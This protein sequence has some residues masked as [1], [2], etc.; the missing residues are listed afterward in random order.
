MNWFFLNWN[1]LFKCVLYFFKIRHNHIILDLVRLNEKNDSTLEQISKNRDGL[2]FTIK[3]DN[4]LLGL[5]DALVE[6]SNRETSEIIINFTFLLTPIFEELICFRS[7]KIQIKSF[8]CLTHIL[9]L[10]KIRIKSLEIFM[11]IKVYLS[12]EMLI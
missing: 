5:D 1:K 8:N 10:T 3:S 2:S 4:I 6:I 9:N 12:D 11:S 7:K